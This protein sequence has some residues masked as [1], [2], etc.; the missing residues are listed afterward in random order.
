[1]TDNLFN[2]VQARPIIVCHAGERPRI[3]YNIVL[4]KT[5]NILSQF[6]E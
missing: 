1:M 5:K 3:G 2:H 4:C 6:T